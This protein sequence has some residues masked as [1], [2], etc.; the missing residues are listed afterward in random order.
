MGLLMISWL[1]MHQ[2]LYA[3][4]YLTTYKRILIKASGPENY[5]NTLAND[6][7]GFLWLGTNN[8]LFRFDG[9]DIDAIQLSEDTKKVLQINDLAIHGNILFYATQEGVL[10]LD[11]STYKTIENPQIS[12]IKE[13][14]INIIADKAYGVWWL[15]KDGL[16]YHWKN[17][18]LRKIKLEVGE[19]HR[20]GSLFFFKG[21][22]WVTTQFKGTY[23]VD[24][25]TMR[26]NQHLLFPSLKTNEWTVRKTD[27][28]ELYVISNIGLFQLKQ[29]QTK[30][31]L[32]QLTDGFFNNIITK[33]N[34]KFSVVKGNILV[35]HY[36]PENIQKNISINI[37]ADKPETINK[38]IFNK[39]KFFIATTNGFTVLE[40]K[41]N[42]FEMVHSTYDKMINNFEV[43]RGILETKDEY[44]LSTYDG[45]YSYKKDK[46]QLGQ[47]FKKSDKTYALLKEHDNIW[48]VTDGAGFKKWDLKKNIISN[49]PLNNIEDATNF[50]SI[51]QLNDQ[52]LILGTYHNLISY[53]MKSGV[54]KLIKIQHKNWEAG[55]NFIYCIQPGTRDKGQGTGDTAGDP[56]ILSEAK[57]LPGT[58][59]ERTAGDKFYVTNA[60]GVLLVDVDGKVYADYG[61]GLNNALDKQAYALWISSDKSIWAGTGNGV[62]HFSES[63]KILHHLTTKNG[64][65]GERVASIT[66]D[67][68]NHLWVATFTGLSSINL[69]TLEIKNFTKEEGLPDNEFNHSASL[70]TSTGEI[71]LGTVNGFIKFSPTQVSQ[72]SSEIPTLHISKI[73]IGNSKEEE[74]ILNIAGIKNDMILVDKK[75]NYVKINLFLVP[76]DILQKTTYE[77]KVNGIHA[78][79]IKMGNSPTIYLDN[80]RKGKYNLHIRA[81]TGQGSM[82]I[83]TKNIVVI[84][85]EY[86]YKTPLFYAVLFFT[87]LLLVFLCFL[88]Y[89]KRNKKIV[90]IRQ[91]IAQDLH[92]EIG[93]YITG[94]NMNIELMQQKKGREEEQIQTIQTLGQKALMSLRDSLWSLDIKSD[95]GLQFWDRVKTIASESYGP[96]EITYNISGIDDMEKIHLTM[97]EKNYL[98]YII[99]ECITNS[100]KYGDRKHVDI[101]WIFKKNLHQ[102]IISNGIGEVNKNNQIGQG[103][104]NI[105]SRMKKIGAEAGF[106]KQENLYTVE[107]T[108]NFL[109]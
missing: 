15:T 30:F 91:H 2:G 88:L 78:E 11:L 108:L 98:L 42:L 70:L 64:L 71:I 20:N 1:L 29:N 101:R 73:E 13:D 47:S 8:G 35:Y 93:S 49:Q 38:L 86:F 90:E 18:G 21:N 85:D 54:G 46:K 72:K 76:L 24:G 99:K 89:I 97:L 84:V 103:K 60:W 52:T 58:K 81:I 5:I 37:G 16:L 95:N 107:L 44:L 67:K 104:Y 100:L 32:Q 102:I 25:N 43:P 106:F 94:I 34:M 28:D 26:I 92:D 9:K 65:T 87:F 75:Y 66:P 36:D 83:I 74:K 17:G 109:K 33:N 14:I 45:I 96:L 50:K 77:Y 82:N 68:N 105:N 31:E 80:F 12:N 6:S 79:W 3:Q 59:D 53:D 4:E 61:K 19:R 69:T 40:F 56:V 39:D 41:K 7:K 57:E 22:I 51:A 63:G 48:M 27:N 62:Y 23:I 10:Q 55:R